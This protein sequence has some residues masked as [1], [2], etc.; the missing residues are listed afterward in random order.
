MDR[1]NSAGQTDT[2]KRSGT[3]E[4]NAIFPGIYNGT[5]QTGIPIVT[6][7]SRSLRSCGI[8]DWG[9]D[10]SPNQ[11]NVLVGCFVVDGFPANSQYSSIYVRGGSESGTSAYLAA[12]QSG[13]T[14]YT[15]DAQYNFNSSGSPNTVHRSGTGRYQAHLPHMTADAGNIQVTA[16]GDRRCKITGRSNGTNELIVD[17]SC[18]DAFGVLTD[19]AFTLLYTRNVGPTTVSRPKA[20]Y[21]FA[22]QPSA[23]NYTPDAAFRY[24]SAGMSSS[25]SRPSTG[26]YIAT[27]NGMPK[28]GAAFVTAVGTDKSFCQL[29][30]IRTSGSPQKIGVA[31]YKLSGNPVDSKFMLTYTK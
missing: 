24:S 17:V 11:A 22:N 30:G 6:A 3:G 8:D 25:I 14:D 31:C 5:A 1:G 9:I 13:T 12:L 16:L 28:G 18:G 10:N 27:L 20:A 15:P 7:M 2:A 21:L 23:A 19:D 26:K 29:T 4:Y